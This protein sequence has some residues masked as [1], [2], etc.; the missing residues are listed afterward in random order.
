MKYSDL[1]WKIRQ[2]ATVTERT[3]YHAHA[4]RNGGWWAIDVPEAPGAF[5]QVRRL[6]QAEA[7]T[8]EMLTLL[9]RASPDSFSISLQVEIPKEASAR[10]AEW[11]ALRESAETAEAQ[12]AIVASELA[13]TLRAEG[14][15]VRDV[16]RVLGVSYQRASQLA[17]RKPRQ[18][19]IAASG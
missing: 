11:R 12:A 5:T 2:A 10:V 9:L 7:M 14:L 17:H 18:T 4:V 1:V 16:G 6:D 19:R 3:M 13:S 8:R 15:T